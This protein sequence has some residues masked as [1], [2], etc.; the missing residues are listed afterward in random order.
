M[1]KVVSTQNGGYSNHRTVQTTRH[2]HVRQG[3]S[4]LG[5]NLGQ[6]IQHLHAHLESLA[7]RFPQPLCSL[8]RQCQVIRILS[9]MSPQYQKQTRK[10]FNHCT[11]RPIACARYSAV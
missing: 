8:P 4:N 11:I 5:C 6:I 10:P 7:I 2:A 3:A 1:T 9:N